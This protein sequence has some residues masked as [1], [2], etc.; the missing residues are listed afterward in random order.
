MSTQQAK[1]IAEMIRVNQAGEYGAKRIY[2]GQI[3]F[4]KDPDVTQTLQHMANQEDVH[5]KY[6]NRLMVE[7]GVRPTLLTPF[8]HVG[9]Y[10]MGAITSAL[11]PKLAHA[12]TIA[13]EEVIEQH[14]QEQLETLDFIEEY[15]PLKE[16]IKIFQKEEVEH[17]N[18]AANQGGNDHPLSGFVKSAVQFV[19]KTAIQ[20]SKKI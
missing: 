15:A 10:L 16:Q 4:N 5:L 2:Q 8:W 13:V 17:A 11:D 3:D 18:I 14:Y 20:I 19:T 9:G 6:F 1:L 7:E 12:C